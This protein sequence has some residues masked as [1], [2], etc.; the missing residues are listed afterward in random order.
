MVAMRRSIS[1]FRAEGGQAR[2]PLEESEEE[3]AARCKVCSLQGLQEKPLSRLSPQQWVGLR[4]VGQGRRSAGGA[5]GVARRFRGFRRS[6]GITMA[7]LYF[8]SGSPGCSVQER[9]GGQTVAARSK[10]GAG[11]GAGAG[12]GRRLRPSHQGREKGV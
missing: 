2:K 8:Q 4:C 5:R 12:G 10:L 11:A 6:G 7:P 3:L 1:L 9:P